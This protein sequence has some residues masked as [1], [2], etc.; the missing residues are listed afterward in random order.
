ME[1]GSSALLVQLIDQHYALLYRFAFRLSGSAA[2]AEDLTQQAFLD[3][4]LNLEQL[5]QPERAKSW[6]CRI[7]RN[8]YLSNRR[9]QNVISVQSLEQTE[10]VGVEPVDDLE[11]DPQ[12]LQ[13]ALEELPEEF[14]TTIIL[15]YFEEFSYK[16]VAEQMDVPV[17]TVMSR[18][19]RA[20]SFLRQRL[21]DTQGPEHQAHTKGASAE[22]STS[23]PDSAP[24]TADTD[25]A[26]FM[27]IQWTA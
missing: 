7:L 11:I 14:R 20:K 15:F 23:R 27:R 22:V 24:P 19:S 17:G 4:Q 26:R 18:L 8:R 6:L 21:M 16:E 12:T 5:R 25:V 2:D 9:R 13:Q 10:E 1:S 3:A